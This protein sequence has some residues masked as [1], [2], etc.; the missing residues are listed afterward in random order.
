MAGSVSWVL[1]LQVQEGRSDELRALM[2]EMVSNTHA[3]E[4]G[5][6]HYEWFMT[7]DGRQCHLYARHAD[8]AAALVHCQ[9]FGARFAG[10]FMSLLTPTRCTVYGSP[11][12]S[13]QRALSVLNPTY[14]GQAAGFHR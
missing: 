8:S 1:E 9:M 13:V 12:A 14:M 3:Q 4:P 7:A 5:T 6:Q 11:D 2:E 10:R